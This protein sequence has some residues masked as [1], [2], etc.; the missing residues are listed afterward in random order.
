MPDPALLRRTRR[1]V[2]PHPPVSCEAARRNP[3]LLRFYLR[4]WR[5]VMT[6]VAA[7][8]S[9]GLV[10]ALHAEG[11]FAEG[12]LIV[13]LLLLIAPVGFGIFSALSILAPTTLFWTQHKQ[14]PAR[15]NPPPAAQS[16]ESGSRA[17]LKFICN[18]NQKQPILDHVLHGPPSN[19]DYTLIVT[20]RFAPMYCRAQVG[21]A[22]TGCRSTYACV[23]AQL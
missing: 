2:G 22:R 21:R 23:S 17:I 5:G 13:P 9:G 4:R 15:R 14:R 8:L 6:A 11:L 19:H 12:P 3:H 16:R 20:F 18:T 10:W 7:R 1:S